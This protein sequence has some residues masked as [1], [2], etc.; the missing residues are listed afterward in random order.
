MIRQLV[1]H[2]IDL[3]DPNVFRYDDVVD[4]IHLHVWIIIRIVGIQPTAVHPV[5]DIKI[6]QEHRELIQA[7]IGVEI[8]GDDLIRRRI[9][10][11]LFDQHTELAAAQR[12]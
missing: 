7:L 5:S 8:T 12:L 10:L 11:Y 1:F 6:I 2:H 4:H 9:G 3:F